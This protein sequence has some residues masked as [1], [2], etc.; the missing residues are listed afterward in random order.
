[1]YQQRARQ[2]IPTTQNSMRGSRRRPSRPRSIEPNCT[3]LIEA[4]HHPTP[5][6]P[7]HHGLENGF[8]DTAVAQKEA[9]LSP[10]RLTADT[11]TPPTQ[12]EL[13]AVKATSTSTTTTTTQDDGDSS[14][15]SQDNAEGGDTPKQSRPKREHRRT[16]SL[17]TER[18]SSPSH[19]LPSTL[20]ILFF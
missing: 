10:R 5:S 9:P 20:L 7:H 4:S 17:G 15:S 13:S 19:L 8:E 1:M 6:P 12:L 14:D 11:F 16:Q 18:V 2:A 3:N